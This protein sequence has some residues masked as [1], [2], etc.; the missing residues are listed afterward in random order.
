MTG[1]MMRSVT[2]RWAGLSAEGGWPDG[3]C[4]A[5]VRPGELNATLPGRPHNV[6]TRMDLKRWSVAAGAHHQLLASTDPEELAGRLIGGEPLR[7]RPEGL[8]GGVRDPR[9]RRGRRR[10]PGGGEDPTPV[11]AA[12]AGD[13]PV[14]DPQQAPPARFARAG[15]R[16]GDRSGTPRR[17]PEADPAAAGPPPRL[18]AAPGAGAGPA[19]RVPLAE[20]AGP[21]ARASCSPP[22]P[23]SP[24]VACWSTRRTSCSCPGPR[25]STPRTGRSCRRWWVSG[26][27]STSPRSDGARF[28]ACCCPRARN[29]QDLPDDTATGYGPDVLAGRPPATGVATGPVRI[30]GHPSEARL[31]PGTILPAPTTDPGWTRLLLTLAGLITETG[32]TIAHGPTMAGEDGIPALICVPQA[33]TGPAEGQLITVDGATGPIRRHPTQEPAGPADQRDHPSRPSRTPPQLAGEPSPPGS[34]RPAPDRRESASCA[35][36]GRCHPRR[37]SGRGGGKCSPRSRATLAGRAGCYATGPLSRWAPARPPGQAEED[38]AR[39][40]PPLRQGSPGRGGDPSTHDHR[41]P[42]S[43]RSSRSTVPLTREVSRPLPSRSP[44]D[45]R[46]PGSP[47]T[48]GPGSASAPGS[49][50]HR[51]MNRSR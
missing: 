31:R 37:G 4:A 48:P 12:L 18:P 1:P 17:A 11:F 50:G 43:P 46:S 47:P 23:T 21:G 34:G 15:G 9:Q 8:P 39:L 6:T 13:L 42:R 22:G 24:G 2:P 3:C 16:S 30:V 33:T 35:P 44:R 32:S 51:P 38:N 36:T 26:A 14:S 5:I 25:P 10:P 41:R 27:G 20:P 40:A 19:G 28:R 49:P 29:P 7:V 45:A